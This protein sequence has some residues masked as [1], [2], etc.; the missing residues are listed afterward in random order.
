MAAVE[1]TF[2]NL[3]RIVEEHKTA[4]VGDESQSKECRCKL[5]EQQQEVD[6][7]TRELK[8]VRED[9]RRLRKDLI[10]EKRET[11]PHNMGSS[12][13]ASEQSVASRTRTKV[14]HKAEDLM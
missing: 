3:Q 2:Q 11:D 1:Q 13:V 8:Q 12:S 9:N 14:S 4:L 6:T 5:V 7:K 10:V